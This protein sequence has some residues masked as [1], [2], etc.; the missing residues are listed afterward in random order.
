MVER[1]ELRKKHWNR[2]EWNMKFHQKKKKQNAAKAVQILTKTG[3]SQKKKNIHALN[4]SMVGRH[5][6]W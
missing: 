2:L 1:Q 6:Y 4:T 5:L 3:R